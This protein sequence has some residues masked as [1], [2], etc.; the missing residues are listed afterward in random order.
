MPTGALRSTR[1]SAFSARSETRPYSG[2]SVLPRSEREPPS[3]RRRTACRSRRA[4]APRW[5][6]SFGEALDDVRLHGG[7]AAQ[8]SA[9]ALGA[10]AYTAGSD[11]VLGDP[12]LRWRRSSDPRSRS[13]GARAD[14]RAATSP[15]RA[16]GHDGPDRAAPAARPSARPGETVCSTDT[17]CRSAR[18][19]R[20][21]TAV[22]LTPT[23]DAVAFDLS[24][25]LDDW[26]VTAA[27]ETRILDALARD[28]GPLG[29]DHRPRDCRD[30]RRPVRPDRRARQ[31]ATAPPLPRPRAERHRPGPRGAVR[32][33]A[34]HRRR[35]AVQPRQARRHVGRARVQSGAPRGS[36][37][38]HGPHV[39]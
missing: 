26:A 19:E 9:R 14:P 38:R 31:P 12:S 24:Y 39:R 16:P 15:G 4:C 25:A 28:S 29:D 22:A 27:E 5:S 33:R 17:G 34:R 23:S 2:C 37:R 32:A 30:A 10:R 36:R 21:P 7:P 13:V 1:S 11:I 20:R 35:A 8:R 3:Q 6:P 18:C